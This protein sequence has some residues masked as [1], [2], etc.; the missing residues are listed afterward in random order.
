MNTISRETTLTLKYVYLPSHTG[1]LLKQMVSLKGRWL[2]L[3]YCMPSQSPSEKRSSLKGKNLHWRGDPFSEGA[4]HAVK[5]TGSNKSC[6]HVGY[7][8][9]SIKC[10]QSLNCWWKSVNQ[11]YHQNQ[12]Q[13][14]TSFIIPVVIELLQHR[15][16]FSHNKGYGIIME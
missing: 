16:V 8:E 1:L 12:F 6:L 2:C 7:D 9:N 13:F 5:Q 15:L 10:I 11:T 14:R 3:H 4:W